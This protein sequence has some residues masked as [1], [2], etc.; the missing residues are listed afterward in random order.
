M[1]NLDGCTPLKIFFRAL[2]RLSCFVA[3]VSYVATSGPPLLP[4]R[5]NCHSITWAQS[6]TLQLVQAKRIRTA[7]HN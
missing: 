4:C 1:E 6:T 7:L 3:L 2:F 5:G